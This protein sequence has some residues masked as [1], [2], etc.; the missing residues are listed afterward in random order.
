MR[1]MLSIRWKL[2]LAVTAVSFL[3]LVGLMQFNRYRLSKVLLSG[4]QN[5]VRDASQIEAYHFRQV[6]E[7]VIG[8][9]QSIDIRVQSEL[10]LAMQKKKDPDIQRLTIFASAS[11]Q[12]SRLHIRRLGLILK[13]G[14]ITHSGTGEADEAK[15]VEQF[16]NAEGYTFIMYARDDASV[17]RVPPPPGQ[18]IADATWWKEVM[19]SGTEVVQ[20]SFME[21]HRQNGGQDS[22]PHAVARFVI[23]VFRDKQVIGGI[24]AEY[25]LTQYHS[26]MSDG[27]ID[28]PIF[29]NARHSMLV[30]HTGFCVET[31]NDSIDFA[32]MM[33]KKG[34]GTEHAYLDE[35]AFPEL[36]AAIRNN[37]T[38]SATLELG[39]KHRRV[40]VAA[41]PIWSENRANYWSVLIFQPEDTVLAE[42]K[43]DLVGYYTEFLIIFLVSLSLGFLVAMVMGR[44]MSATEE[45][46]RTI[47]DRVPMPLGILGR[48]SRWAYVNSSFART[49]ANTEPVRMRGAACRESL[50]AEYSEFFVSTNRPDASEVVVKE[51]PVGDNRSFSF[52]SCQLLDA[53]K[54]YLGRLII[55]VDI[56]DARNIVRTLSAAASI[57]E[58]LDVNSGHIFQVAH[59]IMEV[60]MDKSAAIEEIT[61]NTQR[62]GDAAA[63]YAESAKKSHE[64]AEFTNQAASKGAYEV[65]RSAAAMN[66]VG[67]SGQKITSIIKL[68]DDI[69]FQTNLL[70]LNA[71]VEAARAGRHGKGFAVVAGEV[72]NLAGRSAKAA[73]ETAGIIEEMIRRIGETAESI[74]Q[75][76]AT[77]EQ[78]RDNARNLSENS[79]E[80]ARLAGQQS[81]S[82]KEVHASLEEISKKIYATMNSSRETA[83]VAESIL[84]QA[85]LL[86]RLTQENVAAEGGAGKGGAARAELA[87]DETPLRGGQ[88]IGA[89]REHPRLG[90]SR[91]EAG[92]NAAPA[93]LP[94]PFAGKEGRK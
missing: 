68:I 27:S 56:T 35:A 90:T 57:A 88:V 51:Y 73:R 32:G 46:Y 92:K 81:V 13:P 36:M 15:W 3:S 78:I 9:M 16:F 66:G 17:I 44:T 61:S 18:T 34:P 39:P 87:A 72:R 41:C 63:T 86:H 12:K 74:Q 4:D 79:D 30:S 94:G 38:Y 55:G 91:P 22:K 93:A 8:I 84:R 77:L 1:T 67:E 53:D 7:N 45:W 59:S 60:A 52:S 58:S 69:A 49:L 2:I 14:V 40:F 82:V 23:P 10:D 65:S 29:V 50:R 42:A 20:E 71:A 76:G 89:P 37:H 62:I 80:V 75:L 70:A 64:Q 85:S 83:N 19:R 31:P 48:D 24:L 47:L 26:S 54:S 5:L 21:I 33:T 25:C 28:R 11:L 6:A 43:G